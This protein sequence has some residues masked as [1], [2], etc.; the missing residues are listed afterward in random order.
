MYNL[1]YKKLE[2]DHP[3]RLRV[4]KERNKVNPSAIEYFMGC[5]CFLMTILNSYYKFQ[6]NT[7]IFM[8]NPCHIVNILLGIIA[9]TPFSRTNEWLALCV[10]SAAFGGYI[11]I[12]FNEN[13]EL[14]FVEQIIYQYEHALASYLGPLVLSLVGRYDPLSYISFPLPWAGYLL[15]STYMRLFLTPLSEMT[16]ANLNHT[17]CGLD[18]DPF[19]HYFDMGEWYYLWSDIYLLASCYFWVMF[20]YFLCY[21]VKR[22]VIGDQT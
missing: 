16:W 5:S 15:F 14:S 6:S 4:L 20:N 7:L 18:N 1:A 21:F 12:I 3:S 10:Y 9:V 17:L 2:G 13:E 19:Y 22:V 11:G 8:F